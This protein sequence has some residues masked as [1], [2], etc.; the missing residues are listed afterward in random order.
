MG[1]TLETNSW[2]IDSANSLTVSYVG[3]DA[4]SAGDTDCGGAPVSAHGLST[5]S[6]FYE[7]ECT[8]GTSTNKPWGDTCSPELGTMTSEESRG[9]FA[10]GAAFHHCD[11]HTEEEDLAVSVVKLACV[12]KGK[13]NTV[14]TSSCY[15]SNPIDPNASECDLCAYSPHINNADESVKVDATSSF[16]LKS[17]SDDSHEPCCNG[18]VVVTTCVYCEGVIATGTRGGH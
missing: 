12:E 9:T 17:M 1:S 11:T 7:W 6:C 16:G 5:P 8:K 4:T 18:A 3:V 13:A 10:A 2:D 15:S 14:A